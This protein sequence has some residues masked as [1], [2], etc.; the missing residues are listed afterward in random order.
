[1]KNEI[2]TYNH[3][4][5]RSPEFNFLAHAHNAYEL[6]FFIEGDAFYNVEDRKYVLKKYDLIITRPMQSHF[7]QLNSNADYERF[8]ILI[9]LNNKI[10]DYLSALPK[11]T[12]VVNCNSNKIITDCF[13]RMALYENMFKNS[14]FEILM[15]SILTELCFNLQVVN[16]NMFLMPQFVS[17][18]IKE[19][20]S[21]INTHLFTVKDIAEISDY[22]FVAKN[23]FFRLFKD[24]MKIT[25]K[26]YIT[27]KRLLHAQNLI[28]NGEKPT[29]IYNQCG[30]ANYVSFYKC[31][32]DFFGTPPSGKTK[33]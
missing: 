16:K 27:S 1:M 15:T 9:F 33:K 2:F 29:E 3:S 23:Y 28:L 14:E 24:Q 7:V 8:D 19:S 12:E 11:N 4:V 21:Y 10:A 26:K 17:P 32:L 20:L 5:F 18:L 30:F 6:I 13:K 25:P 22:L 31:Y